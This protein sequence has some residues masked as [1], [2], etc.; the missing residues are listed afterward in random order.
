LTEAQLAG[1]RHKV[2]NAVWQHGVKEKLDFGHA[3]FSKPIQRLVRRYFREKSYEE[4][5]ARRRL[6]HSSSIVARFD[7]F[8]KNVMRDNK[9]ADYSLLKDQ[10]PEDML[11]YVLD[12][13]SSEFI[14]ANEV[15]LNALV[16]DLLK[17]PRNNLEGTMGFPLDVLE[18]QVVK[19]Y[20]KTLFE[21]M[22]DDG[23]SRTN[24]WLLLL[25]ARV[26]EIGWCCQTHL[27][28]V[29]DWSLALNK[30]KNANF[31]ADTT[32]NSRSDYVPFFFAI[33]K[34][35][36]Q[37]KIDTLRL[38]AKQ[39]RN[40]FKEEVLKTLNLH[41]EKVQLKWLSVFTTTVDLR[42]DVTKQFL[43]FIDVTAKN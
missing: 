15:V 42:S 19:K 29:G 5:K 2:P 33:Q 30:V 11:E 25:L 24:G 37:I 28:K 38:M 34:V 43:Q 3:Q 10:E 18:R 9:C 39:P 23:V 7:E 6:L 32:N 26:G 14:E 22:S 16:I 35:Y 27:R 31:V 17:D 41:H 36:S 40:F 12:H 1:N 8:L 4:L 13:L 21:T 20:L